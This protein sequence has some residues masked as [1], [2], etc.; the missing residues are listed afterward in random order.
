M[1]KPATGGQEELRAFLERYPATQILEL[2]QPD[3]LG[4]LR[5][6]R[7]VRA[8]FAKPFKDGVNFC[9]ATCCSTARDRPSSASTTAVA[10]ATP[11]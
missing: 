3:M 7:V 8:E 6:K 4:V 1:N 11:T 5:G 9:G 10:M 2:L